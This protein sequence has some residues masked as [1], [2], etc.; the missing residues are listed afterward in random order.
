MLMHNILLL[1]TL[2]ILRTLICDNLLIDVGMR[3]A[4]GSRGITNPLKHDGQRVRYMATG[5]LAW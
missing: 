1:A 3:V 4:P 2:N 5:H